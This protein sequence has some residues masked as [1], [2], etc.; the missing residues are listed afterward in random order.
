MTW[1]LSVTIR[2]A[3][4]QQIANAVDAGAGAGVLRF[5]TAPRPATGAAISTQTLLAEVTLNDPAFAAAAAGQIVLDNS[6]QPEDPSINATGTAA[7][8]RL[9]DS[10]GTF[11]GDATV[12]A[13]GSGADIELDSVDLALG[14]TLRI[15]SGTFTD[16]NA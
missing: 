11:I 16:G 14:G 7:W 15:T 13:T 4:V 10:V 6:P 9:V 5:Y 1:A 2:N 12:G 3:R 8:A